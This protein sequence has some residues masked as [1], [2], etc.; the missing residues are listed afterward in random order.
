MDLGHYVGGGN[1]G[2]TPIDFMNKFH[3]RVASFH[4]KDQ[5][6]PEHCTLNLAWGTGETPIKEILQLVQKN[7]WPIPATIEHFMATDRGF[8]KLRKQSPLQ[9]SQKVP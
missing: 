7:K 2:G 9:D 4:L 5:T 3:D 6:L 8:A 1:Q